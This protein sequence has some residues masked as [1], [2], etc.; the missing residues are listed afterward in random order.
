MDTSKIL[1]LIYSAVWGV[2]AGYL[3]GIILGCWNIECVMGN[4]HSIWAFVSPV[5]GLLGAV[6]GV[7]AY[8]NK[9]KMGEIFSGLIGGLIGG[10]IGWI[11]ASLFV[12]IFL[13]WV[14]RYE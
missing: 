9:N 14:L 4:L 13:L 7:I 6:F 1:K 8:G 12:I 11:F 2:I 10:V 5:G 3:I